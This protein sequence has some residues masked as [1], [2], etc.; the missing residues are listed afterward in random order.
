[1]EICTCE[2]ELKTVGQT[3]LL[4]CPCDQ[5]LCVINV[6]DAWGFFDVFF[7]M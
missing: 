1:M 4:M 6:K 3:A 5:H 7:I 2:P